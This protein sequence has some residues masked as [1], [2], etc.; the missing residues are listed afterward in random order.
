LR[1][2]GY[3]VDIKAEHLVIYNVPY[4]NAKKEVKRGT[5]I[6]VLDLADDVTVRPKTHIAKFAGEH[7]CDKDGNELAKIKHQSNREDLGDGLVADHSFSSKPKG[8]YTDYYHKMTTYYAILASQAEAL[9]PTVAIR[10]RRF[11]EADD[12]ESVF[13]Y[14]DTASGRAG[15]GA[16]T[17]KL[18]L[19]KV[20]IVGVGGTGAYTFDLVTKTPVREIHIFDGDDFLQHNAFRTPGAATSEELKA[21]LKKVDYLAARYAPMRKGIILHPFHIDA[22]NVDMLSDMDFVF[23]CIDVGAAKQVIIEKLEAEGIPFIDVGMGVE[24]VNDRLQG[25]VRVTTS[26]PTMR[27]HV[28]D[29]KRICLTGGTEDAVYSKNIQIADLNALNAAL[30]VIKWKKLFGFYLDL[31]SEH[32]SAYTLDGNL[33]TNEDKA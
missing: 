20:G 5:L 25:I 22:S 1:E 26:T 23:I 10:D 16:V 27:D 32:F 31:D 24:L 9:D 14:L 21:I 4:V 15:I 18:E 13:N 12:P 11:I 2:D 29:R 30:A 17:R 7:P 3:E 28:R 33:I 19:K 8:D 6:S